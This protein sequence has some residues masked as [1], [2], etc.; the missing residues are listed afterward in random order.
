MF[1]LSEVN[2]LTSVVLITAGFWI[3]T[4]DRNPGQGCQLSY[5]AFF[6]LLMDTET[7]CLWKI[8]LFLTSMKLK[9]YYEADKHSGQET[10]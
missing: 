1:L 10:Y 8:T 7:Q 9:T 4:V 6:C 5:E 3:R 2:M